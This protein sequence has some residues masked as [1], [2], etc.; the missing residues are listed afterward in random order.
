MFSSFI[1]IDNLTCSLIFSYLGLLNF[2]FPV[3]VSNQPKQVPNIFVTCY[4]L[5][6]HFFVYLTCFHVVYSG[7]VQFGKGI[8]RRIFNFFKDLQLNPNQEVTDEGQRF[9]CTVFILFGEAQRF[10]K[11]RQWVIDAIDRDIAQTPSAP[12]IKLFNDWKGLSKTGMKLYV[13]LWEERNL[14]FK[15]KERYEKQAG[16]IN[17]YERVVK[18][19]NEA[20]AS[21]EQEHRKANLCFRRRPT[22]EIDLSLLLGGEILLVKH[23]EE[24]GCKALIQEGGQF[25]APWPKEATW[26]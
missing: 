19:A 24:F 10:A 4:A 21:K 2:F 6:R 8:L 5:F 12:L 9:V 13:A 11:A 7:N 1:I 23:D 26:E 17:P 14:L 15:Y 20:C 18:L 3:C 16:Y 25:E 22:A